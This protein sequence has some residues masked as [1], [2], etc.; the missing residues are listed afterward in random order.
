VDQILEARTKE[1]ALLQQHR[2]EYEAAQRA[3]TEDAGHARQARESVESLIRS[4]PDTIGTQVQERAQA[5]VEQ[6]RDSLEQDISTRV[7]SAVDGLEK[8]VQEMVGKAN[9]EMPQVLSN[10]LESQEKHFLDATAARL[11]ELKELE[12]SLRSSALESAANVAI[13]SE[14]ALAQVREQVQDLIVK[15]QE[16]VEQGNKD[17]VAALQAVA[18][19]LLASM[20]DELLN[21]LG[22]EQ[23]QVRQ[24]VQTRVEELLRDGQQTA[25]AA[26]QEQS[27]QIAGN[28]H[29]ELL[30][31]FEERQQNFETAHSAATAQLQ[32]LEKRTDELTAIVDVDLQT[33]AEETIRE[34]VAQFTEKLQQAAAGVREAHLATAKAELDRSLGLLVNQAGE[35]GAKLNLTVQSLEQHTMAG[36][37]VSAQLRK[38]A[39]GAEAWRARQTQQFQRMIEEAFSEAAGEIRGRIHQAVA[40][41]S[42]PLESRS[43]EIQAEIAAVARQQSEELQKQLGIARQRLQSTYEESQ[44]IAESALQKRATETLDSLKQNAQQLA[45]N[46]IDLWQAALAE[47]LAAIPQILAAKLSGGNRTAER[48]PDEVCVAL[49]HSGVEDGGTQGR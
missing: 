47:T 28:L 14:R 37:A 29:Q 22:R 36:E 45:Q 5:L 10:K 40:M 25:E 30:K 1:D 21:E 20:R 42:E 41:A 17:A 31:T 35:A 11:G 3:I 8:R 4:L 32:Q 46:S 15:Q 38:Q 6:L 9:E 34:A 44:S 48:R 27:K 26:L 24:L 43:R 16:R 7:R 19:N 49:N 33:H 23:D 13:G 39:Q 2:T 12:D 18:G